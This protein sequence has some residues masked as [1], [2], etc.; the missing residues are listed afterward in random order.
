MFPRIPWDRVTD[1]LWSG[2]HTL[3]PGAVEDVRI[4]LVTNNYTEALVHRQ[5]N[6]T[7]INVN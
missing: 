3:G 1:R 7:D 2:E 5:Y 4:N 6:F